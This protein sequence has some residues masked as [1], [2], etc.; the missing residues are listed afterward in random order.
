ME[1]PIFRRLHFNVLH[2][3]CYF[4]QERVAIYCD[5]MRFLYVIPKCLQLFPP[6]SFPFEIGWLFGGKRTHGLAG[7][8][9][10]P[11]YRLIRKEPSD[12]CGWMS[13]LSPCSWNFRIQHKRP[14]LDG[15]WLQKRLTITLF[16]M[17]EWCRLGR[18][19]FCLRAR[20]NII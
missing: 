16:N 11:F 9:L 17:Y 1:Q 19:C 7:L 15:F 18:L 14:L 4:R 20:R 5:A 8:V 3:N 12:V 6:I 2:N 10:H 13:Y